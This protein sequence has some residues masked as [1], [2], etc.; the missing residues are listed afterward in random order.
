MFIAILVLWTS[1][2]AYWIVTLIVT[3]RV[4]QELH[5]LTSQSFRGV[6][7]VQACLV[8]SWTAENA[9]PTCQLDGPNTLAF[10]D[11]MYF[12]RDYTEVVT[13]TIGVSPH[14]LDGAITD[15][16]LKVV[17]SDAIVWWRAWVLW[18]HSRVLRCLCIVL[19]LLTI[20]TFS[21][22]YASLEHF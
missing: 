10:F 8:A 3:A 6:V 15:L 11:E 17:V 20:S 12:I 5:D 16:P 22:H 2:A 4:F 18:P 13:L 19:M 14:C 7:D 21:A 9:A 1:T